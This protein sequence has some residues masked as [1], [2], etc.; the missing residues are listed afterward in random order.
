MPDVK[1]QHLTEDIWAVVLTG[2]HDATT[3]AELRD[4]LG[5]ARAAN[6]RVV[7]DLADATFLDSIILGVIFEAVRETAYHDE[8]TF[9]LVAAPGSNVDRI[10][11]LTGFTSLL[12]AIYPSRQAVLQAWSTT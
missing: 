1:G 6:R 8:D 2:E 7:L 5:K 10:L 12:A 11:T 9:A 4:V 3:A